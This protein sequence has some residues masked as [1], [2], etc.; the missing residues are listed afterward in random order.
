MF[1]PSHNENQRIVD[2]YLSSQVARGNFLASPAAIDDYII[3]LTGGHAAAVDQVITILE[4]DKHSQAEITN[5]NVNDIT[6]NTPL[7]NDFT[8]AADVILGNENQNLVGTQ[9]APIIA[10]LEPPPLAIWHITRML[11][12]I[13]DQ[14][15]MDTALFGGILALTNGVIVRTRN[16]NLARNIF[17]SKSNGEFAVRAYDVEYDTKA[18]AGFFGF[19]CRRSFAGKD[20]QDAQ[21]RLDGS[22]G[23]QLQLVVQDDLTGLDTFKIVAQG[24]VLGGV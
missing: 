16:G 12:E 2:L 21:V 19:R 4:G 5:V 24:H 7:D 9:A 10:Y 3:T 8:A 13:S 1:P 11:I 18:P 20:K 15:A 17:T 14:T 6:I 23:E 22:K